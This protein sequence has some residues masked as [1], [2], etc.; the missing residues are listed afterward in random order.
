MYTQVKKNI[1]ESKEAALAQVK[2]DAAEIAK[3]TDPQAKM[4][5]Q[6]VMGM[7]APMLE[8]TFAEASAKVDEV[9]ADPSEQAAKLMSK[10]D[11]NDD[12]AISKEEFVANGHILFP[13][14][15]VRARALNDARASFLLLK[16]HHVFVWETLK[17]CS[18]LTMGST[19]AV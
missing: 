19:N 1:A 2:S 15:V 7:I 17:T 13:Q 6:M 18:V 9:I 5:G 14:K 4:M 8:T 16:W 10:I 3:E 11:T 12:K